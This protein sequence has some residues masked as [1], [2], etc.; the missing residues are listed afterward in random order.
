M[1][2]AQVDT[3]KLEDSCVET[4]GVDGGK[5]V[6]TKETAAHPSRLVFQAADKIP[7]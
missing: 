5:L 4:E 3:K 1:W 7:S 2:H 6:T